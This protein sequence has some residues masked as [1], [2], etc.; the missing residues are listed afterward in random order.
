MKIYPDGIATKT[1]IP[2][3]IG[4]IKKYKYSPGSDYSDITPKDLT[5]LKKV[6]KPEQGIDFNTNAKKCDNFVLEYH[7]KIQYEALASKPGTF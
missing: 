5:A 2:I 6:V 3:V 7:L 4:D 1:P